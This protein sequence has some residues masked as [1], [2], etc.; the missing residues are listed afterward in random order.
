MARSESGDGPEIWSALSAALDTFQSEHE[1]QFQRA[2]EDQALFDAFDQL[3]K[4]AVQLLTTGQIP[5]ELRHGLEFFEPGSPLQEKVK[6]LLSYNVAQHRIEFD[7]GRDVVW[8]LRGIHKRIWAALIAFQF[9]QRARP[10]LTAVKYL[11]HAS[12]SYLAGYSSEVIIMCGAVLEAALATRFPDTEL[13]AAGWKPVYKQT[14]VFSLG[15][16]MH[17]EERHPVLGPDLRMQ[18]QDVVNWRND[19]LHVQPDLAPDP[20]V[21]LLMTAQLLGALLPR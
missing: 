4:G 3:D 21:T 14:G 11:E 10:S 2:P 9:L 12:T 16:R 20:A 17:Y 15:Q 7:I 1:E 6:E 13:A 8:R 5:E 19:A 18:L